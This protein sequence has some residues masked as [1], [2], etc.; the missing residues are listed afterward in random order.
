MHI[1][2][3][4]NMK[5]SISIGYLLIISIL[6]GFGGI[7][8]K[9]K[10]K[11]S[12]TVA[13]PVKVSVIQIRGNS[14]IES[15]E[16]PATVKAGSSTTLSFSVS[17]TVESLF[18]KEGQKVSKGQLLGKVRS[19]DYENAKNIA[20]AQLA[21]AQDGYERL[22]KLHDA[23]ALP[24]IKWVE[25]QQKLAQAQNAAEMAD[26]TLRDASLYSPVG[27]TVSQ[28]FVE[29]GQTVIPVQPIYEIIST[30]NLEVVV[31]ISENEISKFKTGQ[32]A[33][34]SFDTPGIEPI[35]GKVTNRAITADP[36]TRSYEVK[37]S[38]PLTNGKILPGMI[39]NVEFEKPESAS[40]DVE[41]QSQSENIILPS[42]SV[43]LNHDN[44]WFVWVVKDS[45]AQRRFVEVDEFVTN[46]I[47]VTSGLK[48][49][50]FVIVE[51]MQK[52][53]SGSKV[54]PQASTR[55]L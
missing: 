28:K 44:R 43:L 9:D 27:G 19:G 6:F 32:K 35:E 53:G 5:K 13:P 31:P 41:A 37:V 3:A 17:G 55:G 42:G 21:E 46:G 25:I 52:V 30:D 39:A 14:Q 15:R 1:Q 11:E 49:G 40:N 45:V 4:I 22:K 20:Y 54:N 18:A 8:C 2:T 23:N 38:L 10:K 50:D 16:Y 48:E 47:A 24:D 7:S 12:P 36:L 26:R 34:I 51:G 29:P 33:K